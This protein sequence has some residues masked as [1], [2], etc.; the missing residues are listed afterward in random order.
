MENELTLVY[1][2]LV[3]KDLAIFIAVVIT[4]IK[5]VSFHINQ[6]PIL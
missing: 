2:F 3:E 4:E 6:Q 5:L 1:E